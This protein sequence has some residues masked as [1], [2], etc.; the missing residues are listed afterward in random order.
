MGGAADRDGYDET[1]EE[2]YQ[3]M[4]D[5]EYDLERDMA[6][7]ENY[8]EEAVMTYEKSGVRAEG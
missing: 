4:S 1:E 7:M 6:D 2:R 3:A 5:F 8:W